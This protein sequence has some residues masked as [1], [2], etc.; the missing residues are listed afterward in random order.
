M[1]KSVLGFVLLLLM[2]AV[3]WATTVVFIVQP[4]G[5]IPNGVT[6]VIFKPDRLF[7]SGKIDF[8]ETPDHFQYKNGGSVTLLGRGVVIGAVVD[9]G[10]ILMRLPYSSK[11]EY[12]ANGGKYWY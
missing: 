5:M 8:L 10:T 1:R 3:I 12:L 6:A 2:F 9:S 11:L 7:V 4:I